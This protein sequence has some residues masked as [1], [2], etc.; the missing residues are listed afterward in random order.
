M[1]VPDIYQI[2]RIL[3]LPRLGRPALA[4]DMSSSAATDPEQKV[5]VRKPR[6]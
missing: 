3:R 2:V 1:P 5:C 6:Q 4:C